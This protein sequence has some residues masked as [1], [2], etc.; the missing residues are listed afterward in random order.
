MGIGRFLLGKPPM[1][2]L[3]RVPLMRGP[4]P[5]VYGRPAL[6]MDYLAAQRQAFPH[7]HPFTAS[8]LT[9]PGQ[10]ESREVDFCPACRSAEQ[11]WQSSHA[12]GQA[13]GA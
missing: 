7:A 6:S 12:S 2:K 11:A 5:I 9:H 4:V 10:P 1:C 8:C 3:H 13:S